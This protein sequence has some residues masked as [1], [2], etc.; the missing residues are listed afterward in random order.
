MAK[1]IVVFSDGTGNKGGTTEDTNVFKLYNAVKGLDE[2]F[3]YYDNGV[4]TSKH[5]VAR[6][7]GGATGFGFRGNV[8]DLYEFVGRH[9]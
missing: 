7:I 9:Y 5:A 2:Q 6:A 4:G 3:T 1:N 8:R